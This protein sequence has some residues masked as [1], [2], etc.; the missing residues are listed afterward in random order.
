MFGLG[1]QEQR[2]YTKD[3]APVAAAPAPEISMTEMLT[4]EMPLAETPTPEPPTPTAEVVTTKKPGKQG[5]GRRLTDKERMEIIELTRANPRIRHVELAL[6]YNVNESTIRRWRLAPNVEKVEVRYNTGAANVRDQRQR[7]QVLKSA[8]F[9]AA[10][11]AWIA[12]Q[13]AQG[14]EPTPIDVRM[15]AREL[16]STFGDM[17]DFKAST[18]WYYRF[19]RRYGLKCQSA[20]TIGAAPTAEAAAQTTAV[21]MAV[22]A[23][24]KCVSDNSS[25]SRDGGAASCQTNDASHASG[26][27]TDTSIESTDMHVDDTPS[28]A[29]PAVS[30]K[31]KLDDTLRS[32]GE[33]DTTRR[34]AMSSS[35]KAHPRSAAPLTRASAALSTVPVTPVRVASP[36]SAQRTTPALRTAPLTPVTA[37]ALSTSSPGTPSSPATALPRSA[38]LSVRQE[39]IAHF[40]QH[41]KHLLSV[42]DRLRFIKHLAHTIEDAEMY[43]IM[44][45]ETRVEFIKEF[46][47][48]GS[49]NAATHVTSSL[50][51][52]SQAV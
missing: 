37:V 43:T 11:Y 30:L 8:E 36:S 21:A 50:A 45:D 13:R 17:E 42:R 9:D 35:G 44:D 4:S 31:R 46:S 48:G 22:A 33:T 26:S 49:S 41:H 24:L 5:R 6:R 23:A 27:E 38:P 1:R 39:A 20:R 14:V 3:E 40:Q 29:S 12:A 52:N 32:A 28:A 47:E 10:I 15:K 19:C 16:A 25:S 2:T 34:A 7:G 51:V 18:G